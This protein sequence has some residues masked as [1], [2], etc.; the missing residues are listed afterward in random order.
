M[1]LP[2]AVLSVSPALSHFIFTAT[3][4][5][6]YLYPQFADEKTEAQEG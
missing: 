1:V 2:R 4:G 6:E 5:S 3:P